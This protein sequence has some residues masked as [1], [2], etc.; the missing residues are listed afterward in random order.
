MWMNVDATICERH[1][2]L[3]IVDWRHFHK[4]RRHS[5]LGRKSASG[6]FHAACNVDAN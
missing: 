4:L 5:I 3:S 1:S 6:V 2:H